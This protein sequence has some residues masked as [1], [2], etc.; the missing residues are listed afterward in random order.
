MVNTRN[1]I[2]DVARNLFAT[3][4][5]NNITML[6]I[7]QASGK[8]R[9][10]LYMYFK[11]KEDIYKAVVDG[12]LGLL[13]D[14]LLKVSEQIMPPKLKLSELIWTHLDTVQ[15][16]INR[17]GTLRSDFFRNI[18]EIERLRRKTDRKEM[19]LLSKILEMG[20][21]RGEFKK[22]DVELTTIILFH[23]VKGLEIPYLRR[24][25]NTDFEKRKRYLVNFVL[26]GILT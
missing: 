24:N 22:M 23:T 17:N 1:E 11:N 7:A 19:K 20:V 21:S 5:K 14:S 4:G 8:G 18:S 3:N 2:I 6:D 12:E 16:I 25:M 13:Y 15:L 9:R 10:T 26:R